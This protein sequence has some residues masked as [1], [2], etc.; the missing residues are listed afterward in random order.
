MCRKAMVGIISLALLIVLSFTLLQA[1]SQNKDQWSP[2]QF[3]MGSWSGV[4]SGKPG[5]AV[6]GSTTFSFDL[7]RKVIVRKNR[8]EYNAKPGEKARFVH[9]DL[10]VIY[11]KPG[12]TGFR[13]VYFDNEDHVIN[14][15]VSFPTD[16][17][18]AIFES[19]S[20][21]NAPR[22]RLVYQ[23]MSDGAMIVEFLI[24]PPG[25]EFKSYTKGT[26]KRETVERRKQR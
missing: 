6:A 11:Q 23:G 3:L 17:P 18:C 21:E 26:V 1:Q 2:F 19:D 12:N 22:F 13:A 24:A 10:M 5:E 4:G 8:A 14:Y 20:R 9:E 16:Q 7:D 15:A 25:G